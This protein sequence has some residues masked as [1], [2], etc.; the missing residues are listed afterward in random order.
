MGS[1][2]KVRI[3][4]AENES[5]HI[6][7]LVVQRDQITLYVI[8]K[9]SFKSFSSTRYRIYMQEGTNS[10]IALRHQQGGCRQGPGESGL[11]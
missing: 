4:Q 2:K 1:E 7:I 8:L 5:K 3:F 11:K 10:Y 6:Q 9:I